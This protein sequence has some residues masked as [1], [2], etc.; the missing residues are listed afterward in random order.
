MLMTR[1]KISR[2]EPTIR[3]SSSPEPPKTAPEERK[4]GSDRPSRTHLAAATPSGPVPSTASPKLGPLLPSGP[5]SPPPPPLA[6][7]P[8]P[9]GPPPP[10]AALPPPGPPPPPGIPPAGPPPP[11]LLGAPGAASNPK[12]SSVDVQA[13][14]MKAIKGGSVKAGLRKVTSRPP[15]EAFVSSV[16]TDSSSEDIRQAQLEERQSLFFDLLEYMEAPEGNL[17]E[18]ID[19]LN[20]STATARGFL[21]SMVKRGWVEGFRVLEAELLA[22][23]DK[24]AADI[25]PGPGIDSSTGDEPQSS[26]GVP[27]PP[28]PPSLPGGF[29]LPPGPEPITLPGGFPPP[30]PPPPHSGPPPPPPPPPFGGPPPPPPPPGGPA[31]PQAPKPAAISGGDL[32]AEL[33][34]QIKGGIKL[35]KVTPRDPGSPKPPKPKSPPSKQTASVKPKIPPCIVFPGREWTSSITLPDI[36]REKAAATPPSNVAMRAHMYR[37]DQAPITLGAS[38]HNLDEIILLRTDN[39]PVSIPGFDEAEPKKDGSL[40]ALQAHQL[41]E[42]RKQ[43]YEQSDWA[44]WSLY[45][46]KLTVADSSLVSHFAQLEATVQGMRALSETVRAEM[47]SVELNA[48]RKAVGSVPIKVRELARQLQEQTG[49]KI[50][51]ESVKLTP[52]FMRRLLR[53]AAK[54]SQGGRRSRREKLVLVGHRSDDEDDGKSPRDYAMQTDPTSPIERRPG[55]LERKLREGTLERR[56][57]AASGASSRDAAVP[58]D[59]VKV[60]TVVEHRRGGSLGMNEPLHTRKL[61]GVGESGPKSPPKDTTI[62]PKEAVTSPMDVQSAGTLEATGVAQIESVKT[63]STVPGTKESGTGM[64]Q[65]NHLE[66]TVESTVVEQ[67]GN[68][69]SDPVVLAPESVKDGSA[70]AAASRGE[71]VEVNKTMDEVEVQSAHHGEVANA[72]A[73]NEDAALTENVT[74]KDGNRSGDDG[75]AQCV[76]VEPLSTEDVSPTGD[77][78]A[79]LEA[80]DVPSDT[81]TTS[82]PR[83]EEEIAAAGAPGESSDVTA[84]DP[85][86][87][88]F[89]GPT[90]VETPE[91]EAAEVN[92]SEQ[93]NLLEETVDSIPEDVRASTSDAREEVVEALVEDTVGAGAADVDTLGRTDDV[94]TEPS[95]DV[96]KDA[97]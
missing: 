43:A 89:D 47:D 34:A 57:K 84:E 40:Q 5:P 6:A 23:V 51:E 68:T 87:A 29:P 67:D 59:V 26:S 24:Q 31:P 52:A 49:I 28:P 81:I 18:L 38:Q 93:A 11:P 15:R 91:L 30:P 39:L 46:T 2:A 97:E 55:T 78:D 64:E 74:L 44:Q 20:K 69:D 33:M 90:N 19:K 7:P 45:Q 63:E 35:R 54:E 83:V 71:T 42:M 76:S 41:W 95:A 88:Q 12:K 3:T 62:S 22:E 80:H 72:A 37:F 86:A 73:E 4:I 82:T 27:P 8:P 66:R 65:T 48:L 60:P 79:T 13:E 9:P 10:P 36:T 1:T 94:S 50:R 96:A 32:Q 77:V 70:E 92:Q 58:S 61:S 14:L 21:Y 75:V 16:S 53:E 17:D 56:A 85:A 25:P